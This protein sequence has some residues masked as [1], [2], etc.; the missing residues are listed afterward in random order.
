MTSKNKH[1]AKTAFSAT[2]DIS[3][4]RLFGTRLLV[5]DLTKTPS[6][7]FLSKTVSDH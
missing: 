5:T 7:I 6:T 4:S 1:I 2:R 3:R